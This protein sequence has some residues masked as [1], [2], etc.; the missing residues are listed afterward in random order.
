MKRTYSH[1][2][3]SNLNKQDETCTDT[4]ELAYCIT[5]KIA[6]INTNT[7]LLPSAGTQQG[8]SLIKF[9]FNRAPQKKNNLLARVRSRRFSFFILIL[10]NVAWWKQGAMSYICTFRSS[11]AMCL[12]RW[13]WE[14]RHRRDRLS[15]RTAMCSEARQSTMDWLE[16]VHAI[17]V[18]WFSSEVHWIKVDADVERQTHKASVIFFE[19]GVTPHLLISHTNT[20][21][22]THAQ[23]QKRK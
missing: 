21:A 8:L 14:Y 20:H 4:T 22:H 10:L 12:L 5:S 3:A 11:I 6:V 17:S 2:N 15:C 7:I 9:I 13:V 18:F 16:T 1:I 23:K 19:W